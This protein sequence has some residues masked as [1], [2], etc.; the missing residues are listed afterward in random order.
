MV[1]SCDFV[2]L[3]H[4]ARAHNEKAHLGINLCFDLGVIYALFGKFD[5]KGPARARGFFVEGDC[6]LRLAITILAND[7]IDGSL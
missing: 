2:A 1:V 3:N 4:G 5:V 6:R 7:L